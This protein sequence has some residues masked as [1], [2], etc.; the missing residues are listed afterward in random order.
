MHR[1]SLETLEDRRLL[2]FAPI[3]ALPVEWD[4]LGDLYPADVAAGDFNN[5]GRIDLV[6]GNYF[7]SVSMFLGNGDGTFQPGTTSPNGTS[8][9]SIALGDFN[10]DGNLDLAAALDDY[11]RYGNNDIGI[12][13]G[14]GDGTFADPVY[15]S[16]LSETTSMPGFIATD[17]MNGDDKLDL[18]LTSYDSITGDE[19]L[20]VLLGN[21]DGNF[22]LAATYGSGLEYFEPV[23]ADIDSDGNVDVLTT[24]QITDSI[25]VLLGNGD[26][27]LSAPSSISTGYGWYSKVVDDFNADG[28]TDLAALDFY[29]NS[30]FVL[31]G[32]GDGTFQT[33]QSSA[34]GYQPYSAATGEFNGDGVLDLFVTDVLGGAS[35]LLG[36]G[37][38]SFAHPI[39]TDAG[40][41]F[42]VVVDDF[43]ADGRSDVALADTNSS[44]LLVLVNDGNWPDPNAPQVQIDDVTVTEGNTGTT[45]AVF[46]V[47]LSEAYSGAVTVD[48]ATADGTA[49]EGSDYTSTSG[50]LTFGAGE[51]SKTISV[52]VIGDTLDEFDE[53]FFVNLSNAAGAQI[54]DSQAVGTI[55]DDDDPPLVA[56]NDVSG[57]E[58]R[59]GTSALVFTVTLSQ[60][61]G[62]WVYVDFATADG[63]ATAGQD[64]V[65]QSGTL[66]FAPG[67]TTKTVMVTVQGDK[68]KE[69]DERFY[70]NLF[71][72][73]G[74]QIADGQGVGT[75]FN[76][77]GGGGRS[78][79]TRT[80][81]ALA[82][83]AAIEDWMLSGRKSRSR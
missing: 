81:S 52:P 44:S 83:D 29:S 19:Q 20:S 71:G 40:E 57:R 43:N 75:I 54:A 82:V 12:L 25:Q 26:G 53:Q 16:F 76:D 66:S 61:S 42:S 74:G 78:K 38:G 72:A 77:D 15:L 17:D 6:T 65:A 58:G 79:K 14:N 21:G 55:Q 36:N 30:V 4:P 46:T 10:A 47:T 9:I 37:D 70:V 24:D 33:A 69:L 39:W 35:V 27:T 45:D 8:P 7:D 67:E 56:V 5:D 64:Y 13:L 63:T 18:V 2:T 41:S 32:N 31:L 1:L 51:T 59:S 50:T 62:K 49:V 28:K 3:T 80:S 23:L 22:T 73:I 11:E 34:A 68:T 48:Y 60:A